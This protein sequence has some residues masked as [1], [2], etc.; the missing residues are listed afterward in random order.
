[1]QANP[2]GTVAPLIVISSNAKYI[3]TYARKHTDRPGPDARSPADFPLRALHLFHDSQ[4]FPPDRAFGPHRHVAGRHIRIVFAVPINSPRSASN[5]SEWYRS[6]RREL[7]TDNGTSVATT[8]EIAVESGGGSGPRTTPES[9]ISE[10]RQNWN[11]RDQNWTRICGTINIRSQGECAY[12]GRVY[13]IHVYVI[14]YY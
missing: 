14:I 3:I 1:M 6:R 5:R 8:A 10:P 7:C 11:A 13:L 2:A 9:E 4:R 12:V